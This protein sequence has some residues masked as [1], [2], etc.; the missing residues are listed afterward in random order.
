MVDAAGKCGKAD[1]VQLSYLNKG[2]CMASPHAWCHSQWQVCDGPHEEA[3][4]EAGGSSGT[5][6]AAAHL[7]LQD[8]TQA[9]THTRQE[10]YG[11]D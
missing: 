9:A 8:R 10:G 7:L 5:D 4:H 1:T 2:S 6:E 3:G 11:E